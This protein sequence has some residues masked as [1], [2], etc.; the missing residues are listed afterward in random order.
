MAYF[1]MVVLLNESG[2]FTVLE[3]TV[4]VEQCAVHVELH[5]TREAFA[6][7]SFAQ[8]ESPERQVGVIVTDYTALTGNWN[9]ISKF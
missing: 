7:T 8:N 1:D 4:L 3:R 2:T 5:G 9:L 6:R